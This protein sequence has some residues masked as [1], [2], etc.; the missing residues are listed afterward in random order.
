MKA[1]DVDKRLAL[2]KPTLSYDDLKDAD[3]IIEA[4]FRDRK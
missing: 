1:E 2:I 4:V 3:V